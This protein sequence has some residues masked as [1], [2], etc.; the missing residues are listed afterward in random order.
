MSNNVNDYLR[1]NADS[2]V[3]FMTMKLI[4]SGKF[5]DQLYPDSNLSIIID[6]FAHLYEALMYNLNHGASEAIFT[7][8][9][10]YENMNRLV[11][12]LRYNP[13][14]FITA[15]TI[16]DISLDPNNP[17]S[18]GGSISSTSWSIPRYASILLSGQDSKGNPIRYSF[19]Q[20]YRFVVENGTTI[21]SNNQQPILYNGTWKFYNKTLVSS[22]LPYETIV[23]SDINPDLTTIAYPFINVYVK[24]ATTGIFEEYFSTNNIYDAVK[25]DKVFEIRM[26]ENKYYELKFGDDI[27]GRKLDQGD[28]I[29]VLYLETNAADGQIAVGAI[30]GE[31]NTTLYVQGLKN[32]FILTSILGDEFDQ[33]SS[34]A[35][36]QNFLDKLSFYNYQA[37]TFIN[38]IETVDEMRENASNWNRFRGRLITSDDF[39]KYLL[40]TNAKNNEIHDIYAMN[41]WEYLSQFYGWLYRFNR[42]SADIRYFGYPYTDSCDFNNVY[43]WAKS[44]SNDGYNISDTSKRLIEEQCNDLKPLTS[45]IVMVDPILVNFIPY[46]NITELEAQRGGDFIGDAT[47]KYYKPSFEFLNE[48]SDNKNHKIHIVREV[49]SLISAERIQRRVYQ[50]IKDFFSVSNNS[51][52]Q[53]VDIADLYRSIINIDGVKEVKTRYAPDRNDKSTWVE[54]DGL[55]FACW[56]PLLVLGDDFQV[57][58]GVIKL[59]NFQFPYLFDREGL[60]ERIVVDTE[61][62]KINQV[63]Y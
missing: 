45:E 43:I 35:E 61:N 56:S 62:F 4:E 7:D 48:I 22:G 53:K 39:R 17:L 50:L 11:K 34:E 38:D 30:D 54:F 18:T 33:Y 40:T 9:Q 29:Y 63:E 55:S 51:L 49:N 19:V 20:D 24:K 28:V 3:E 21:S 16:C 5:S 1:W 2:A 14:G 44:S 23:M 13:R 26:N 42:I 57:V 27:N 59:N 52:G 37:S 10:Y 6:T 58:N 12:L 60:F 15:S 8:T 41:N 25:T 32:S 36:L 46:V 47:N 31:K